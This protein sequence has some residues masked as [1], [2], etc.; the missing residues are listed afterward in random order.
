MRRSKPGGQAATARRI[1]LGLL[2]AFAALNAFGGGYFG[3]SGAEGVPREWLDGSP[4]HDYFVPSLVLF[5][6]IGGA[7]LT[8]AIAVLRGSAHA[9]TLALLAGAILL[10]WLGVQVAI[11]GYVSW[12]QPVTAAV[13][14]VILAL[15]WSG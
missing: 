12:M 6:V 4:F 14:L 9:R 7:L 5:V 2:L 10:G 3:L 15:A 11:I 13:A 8:G 1:S